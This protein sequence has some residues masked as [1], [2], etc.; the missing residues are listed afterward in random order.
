MMQDAILVMNC[1]QRPYGH[2]SWFSVNYPRRVVSICRSAWRFEFLTP[3]LNAKLIKMD[4]SEVN[5]RR[6][7]LQCKPTDTKQVAQLLPRQLALQ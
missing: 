7:G 6:T 4:G 3:L 1:V 5:S 2:R